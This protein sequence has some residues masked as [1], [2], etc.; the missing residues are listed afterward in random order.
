MTRP[1]DDVSVFWS[2]TSCRFFEGLPVYFFLK[3]ATFFMNLNTILK[4]TI[5]DVYFPGISKTSILSLYLTLHQV[6]TLSQSSKFHGSVWLARASGWLMI[7][8]LKIGSRESVVFQLQIQKVKSVQI[9][10]QT[11]TNKFPTTLHYISLYRYYI[12][13]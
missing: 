2:I 8:T 13:F 3:Y 4:L 9:E 5:F 1:Q 10:F 6:S 11:S 12:L 7:F